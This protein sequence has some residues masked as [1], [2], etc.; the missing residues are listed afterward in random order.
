M[1][2]GKSTAA[3]NHMNAHPHKKFI[4]VTPYVDETKRVKAACPALRFAL[5][6]SAKEEFD[7][8]KRQH[9]KHLLTCGMN[10]ATTHVLFSLCDAEMIQFIEE[11]DYTIII[12]EAIGVLD[13]IPA[14][15]D[16]VQMAM[17]SPWFQCVD[18]DDGQVHEIVVTDKEYNG[19]WMKDLKM[20]ASSHQLV[21]LKDD[22]GE[23]KLYCW[24]FN[25]KLLQAAN[26]IFILTY[27]FESSPMCYLLQMEQLEYRH[28]YVVKAAD[29]S[30][31]FSTVERYTPEYTRTLRD[32]IHIVQ[33]ARMNRIGDRDNALS[34]NWLK[35]AVKTKKDG[36]IDD[37]QRNLS[38]YFN[39]IHR[40]TDPEQK[41]WSTHSVAQYALKGKGY[42]NRFLAFNARA[43]NDYRSATV[44]AYCANVYMPLWEKRY[45]E[46]QGVTVDENAY[47]LSTLIQWIWR[48]AIRDGEEIWIYI[49][50]KRMRTLLE[51]WLDEVSSTGLE[52]GD[53]VAT[54]SPYP[55]PAEDAGEKNIA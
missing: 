29:G 48:S 15:S 26:E 17:S 53:D 41:L 39:N 45:Y 6:S 40:G 33:S 42:T 12:D 22:D 11:Q 37:L 5:P 35:N 32:K 4:Y 25:A 14:K 43:T 47:A 2:A 1:G 27:I 24:M 9:F 38:N 19:V 52:G 50:S 46:K 8:Q 28:T 20:Y 31:R 49:P 3:I 13:K 10:I 16:D 18:C 30:L 54:V 51:N 7:H 55:N 21:A 34:I 23:D 44:L 36:R